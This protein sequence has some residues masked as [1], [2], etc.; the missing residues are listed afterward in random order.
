MQQ[1]GFMPHNGGDMPMME[2]VQHYCEQKIRL[3]QSKGVIFELGLIKAFF[4]HWDVS[5]VEHLEGSQFSHLLV[6]ICYRLRNKFYNLM[7]AHDSNPL[8]DL[9]TEN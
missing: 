4:K 1:I 7:L 5:Y 8:E 3:L 2:Q 6:D 9:L